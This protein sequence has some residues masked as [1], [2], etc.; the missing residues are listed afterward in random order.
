MDHIH[1]IV[2]TAKAMGI[3][4]DDLEDT[5][6]MDARMAEK[7]RQHHEESKVRIAQ[8]NADIDTHPIHEE[9]RQFIP[10]Y[11]EES[12]QR[13]AAV[14]WEQESRKKAILAKAIQRDEAHRKKLKQMKPGVAS[15]H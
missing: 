1:W 2:E 15:G 13:N 12:K 4:L 10:G 14:I 7:Q 9:A 5:S 3:P 11:A 8:Y 6:W